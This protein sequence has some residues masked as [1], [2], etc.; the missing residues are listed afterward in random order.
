MRVRGCAGAPVGGRTGVQVGGCAGVRV[1]GWVVG[2]WLAAWRDISTHTHAH[3]DHELEKLGGW[4][5]GR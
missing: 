5:L 3:I 4:L 1:Y 2:G